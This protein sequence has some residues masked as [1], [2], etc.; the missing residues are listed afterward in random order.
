MRVEVV[1]AAVP[2]YDD[3]LRRALLAD[4]QHRLRLLGDRIDQEVR[5]HVID[6]RNEDAEVFRNR[7][8]RINVLGDLLSKN[9]FFF[10]FNTSEIN[11]WF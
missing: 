3:G 9:K 10:V 8:L 5:S 6:V 2:V 1:L 4:Q 7:V 11:L